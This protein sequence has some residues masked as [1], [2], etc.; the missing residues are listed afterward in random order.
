MPA[1]RRRRCCRSS[2]LVRQT[3]TGRLQA[4]R[5]LKAFGACSL[6]H[7]LARGRPLRRILAT[8]RV[9]PS[10]PRRGGVVLFSGPRVALQRYRT[11]SLAPAPAEQSLPQLTRD[12][13]EGRR[14]RRFPCGQAASGPS[15]R[16]IG[17]SL[18]ER[19]V[20]NRGEARLRCVT[21]RIWAVCFL[22]TRGR[23]RGSRET[24]AR[25]VVIIT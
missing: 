12:S 19:A 16:D 3:G 24:T 2:A 7:A 6:R 10:V 4:A 20:S 11:S 14:S 18:R 5:E 13:T 9:P 15:S 25:Q 1:P 8:K 21:G 23:L 22:A 17:T